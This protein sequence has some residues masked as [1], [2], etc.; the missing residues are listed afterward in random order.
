LEVEICDDQNDPNK[1]AFCAQQAVAHGDVAV[2]GAGSVNGDRIMPILQKAGVASF[3]EIAATPLELSSPVSFPTGAIVVVSV[4]TGVMAAN[5]CDAP[6]YVSLQ[7]GGAELT[8]LHKLA[9]TAYGKSWKKEV[10]LPYT[11]TDYSP[12][13]AQATQGTDCIDAG[14]LPESVFQRWMPPFAQA[15]ATQ[16]MIGLQGNLDDKVCKGFEASCKD[17]LSIGMYPPL[18]DPV[19]AD[20]RAS[21]EQYD[22]PED[23]EYN[24]LGALNTWAAYTIF[25]NV[26]KGMKGDVTAKSFLAAANATSD[27]D[28][29][30]MTPP[31]D[32][33]KEWDMPGM[34]RVFS[35]SM[36]V[37]QYQGDSFEPYIKKW[38]DL[39]PVFSG[40]PAAGL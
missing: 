29:E 15:N 31:L 18:G 4:G 36:L 30:G 27:V 33:T 16:R 12:Q 24:S 19:W 8:N 14:L 10:D 37:D 11:A 35:R 17:A 7:G 22:A 13:V 5:N 39:T 9:Y 28:S 40:K 2:V 1:S 26:V 32:F 20:L 25:K 21:L 23:L 34:N 38:V 3:G 6:A